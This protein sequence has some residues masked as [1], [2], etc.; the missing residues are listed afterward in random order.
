M[1][2]IATSYDDLTTADEWTNEWAHS[3]DG[4]GFYFKTPK[5]LSVFA[6]PCEILKLESKR[7]MTTSD[8]DNNDKS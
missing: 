3:R 5:N 8:V 1:F 2:Q 6:L 7:Q 4:T